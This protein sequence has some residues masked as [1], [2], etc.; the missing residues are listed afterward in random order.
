MA[1]VTVEDCLKNVDNRFDLVMVAS[2]R[3]RQLANGSEPTLPWDN[4]KPTV[5]ALREI[6]KGTITAAILE[7]QEVEKAAAE[8]VSDEELQAQFRGQTDNG[9]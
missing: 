3:A 9:A 8:L 5:L 2:K 7:K 6:A 4:D 1:R